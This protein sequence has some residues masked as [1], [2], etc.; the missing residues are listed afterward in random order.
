MPDV[1]YEK[2]PDG[3]GLITLNRPERLNALGGELLPLFGQALLECEQDRDVRCVAITGAGRAF[4][5][6]GDV[7]NMQQRNDG[8][9]DN[10]GLPAN[11]IDNLDV[12]VLTLRRTQA[13]VT[14]KIVTMAKPVVALVNGHAVGAGFSIALACDI[15]LASRNAKFGT[16]FRNV[17]LTGDY[18][19]T[20]L[21]P[22]IIGRAKARELYF[23]AEVLNAETALGLGLV[24]R[25]IEHERLMEEGLAFAAKFA[26]GPTASL[27][28]MKQ[29]LNFGETHSFAETLDH[30]ALLQRIAGLS[31]DSREAVLAF[32]EKR[33]PRFTGS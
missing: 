9:T 3:V 4:C 14:L 24:T 17:G 33:E 29:N 10:A 8:K 23:S 6:G 20:Y 7:S 18:G 22:R 21:L 11:S 30:E 16:A 12:Q 27:G 15:R 1:L 32:T 26:T 31:N 2:R 5:A 28:K 19:G 25:V 13:E